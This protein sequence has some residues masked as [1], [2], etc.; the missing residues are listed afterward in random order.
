VTPV[1]GGFGWLDSLCHSSSGGSQVLPVRRYAVQA[2]CRSASG[3]V[4]GRHAP[5]VVSPD[6]RTVGDLG[7]MDEELLSQFRQRRVSFERRQGHLRRT[8][9]AVSPSRSLHRLAPPVRRHLVA[10]VKPG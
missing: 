3:L 1:R 5:C 10:S 7:G 4:S 6:C 9:R 8:R 2:G